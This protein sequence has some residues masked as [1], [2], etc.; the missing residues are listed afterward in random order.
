MSCVFEGIFSERPCF[1]KKVYHYSIEVRDAAC[2]VLDETPLQADE[3]F[4]PGFYVE[5]IIRF[6][7]MGV[8]IS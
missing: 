6:G 5:Y 2:R 1:P 3:L 8:V 4:S 7:G